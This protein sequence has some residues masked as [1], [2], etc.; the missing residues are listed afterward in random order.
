MVILMVPWYQV[1]GDES[2]LADRRTARA[3]DMS[4]RTSSVTI[5]THTHGRERRAERS[6]DKRELQKAVKDGVKEAANP[7]RGG[8]QRW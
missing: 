3:L 7:G 2:C 5:N 6:I 1:M 4:G 8:D